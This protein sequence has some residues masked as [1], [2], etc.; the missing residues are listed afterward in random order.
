MFLVN[1]APVPVHV[2]VNPAQV[3]ANHP[4]GLADPADE[5]CFHGFHNA[6]DSGDED[7]GNVSDHGN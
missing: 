5:D 2:T 1:H 6:G 7:E 3:P 4:Q